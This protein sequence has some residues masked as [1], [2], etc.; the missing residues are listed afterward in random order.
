MSQD[1]QL[2]RACPRGDDKMTPFR[3]VWIKW[4]GSGICVLPFAIYVGS[5][6]TP[7]GNTA[8]DATEISTGISTGTSTGT[9][10]RATTGIAADSAENVDSE[11]NSAG[12]PTVDANIAS[13]E[14]ESAVNVVI[15]PLTNQPLSQEEICSLDMSGAASL[16]GNF[17]GLLLSPADSS[18]GNFPWRAPEKSPWRTDK[19]TSEELRARVDAV[20]PTN[21]FAYPGR[22]YVI[23]ASE[24]LLDNSIR[25]KAA[26]QA[27]IR[28]LAGRNHRST[29]RL[30][31]RFSDILM[32][33]EQG[34]TVRFYSDL[35]KD[36]IVIVTFFYTRCAGICAPTNENLVRL[37]KL[38]AESS[39]PDVRFISISLDSDYDR[40]EV[41]KA[42]AAHYKS[43]DPNSEQALPRWD[44]VC[45]NYDEIN[46]VRKEMGVYDL[47]PVIDSDRSQHAGILSFGNDRTNR[48]SAIASLMPAETIE[49]SILKIA[50]SQYKDP[51][52]AVG[53]IVSTERWE[54]RGPLTGLRPWNHGLSVLGS[55]QKIPD[56]LQIRGT[57]GIRGE[58]L[59]DLVD[60]S[61]HQGLRVL[62]PYP[63][64]TS[65][66][67]SASG[68]YDH[69]GDRVADHLRVDMG[70][71][72]LAGVLSR[73]TDGNLTIAGVTL[74]EN[75]DLRFPMMI[76]D[77]SGKELLIER[78]P[79]CMGKRASARGYFLDGSFYVTHLQLDDLT[80][81]KYAAEE[82]EWQVRLAVSDSSCGLMRIRGRT[83]RLAPSAGAVIQAIDG[84]TGKPAG[85]CT[86]SATAD[87]H[88]EFS[89]Q[90][91][92]LE[93]VPAFLRFKW[94]EESE[95]FMSD[96]VFVQPSSLNELPEDQH[97]FVVGPLQQYSPEQSELTIGSLA[98]RINN[99]AWLRDNVSAPQS[100][101]DSTTQSDDRSLLPAHFNSGVLV[102]APFQLQTNADPA[103][104]DLETS[105]TQTLHADSVQFIPEECSVA[106]KLESI[107]LKQKT[108]TVEGITIRIHSDA[109]F[110]LTLETAEGFSIDSTVN[111]ELQ[112]LLG[113]QITVYGLSHLV[114]HRLP[115]GVVQTQASVIAVR[116]QL[117][118][119]GSSPD[120]KW[121]DGAD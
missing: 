94:N 12:K 78:M 63:G 115:S 22:P 54:I 85:I 112:K 33:N 64:Q 116:I 93:K 71:H 81:Q 59:K 114:P 73:S 105:P 24:W 5:V 100:D 21:R 31:D 49:Q 16:T 36:Q 46:A 9:S 19:L 86:A 98:L 102:R 7:D 10:T 87:G 80:R 2:L 107:D 84:T 4:L 20:D 53:E 3:D 83:T 1:H 106:G 56:D 121:A 30:S 38:L 117:P 92:D 48:W 40:P 96:R 25:D 57:T 15:C 76:S 62:M 90:V 110:P 68:G 111:A 89:L 14:Q 82:P 108:I 97:G 88:C 23:G 66:M 118:G 42:F 50:G 29:G 11:L 52:Y 67:V 39:C 28:D 120:M 58:Q 27:R 77:L 75:P 72:Q 43:E 32:K 26:I 103:V 74:T 104:A 13:D 37:R 79:L 18:S 55:E 69:R 51:L 61:V 8:T 41:L 109:H 99:N 70:P 65:V 113:K 17:P 101:S 95:E 45:G 35:V 119:T 6:L 47:D 34:E 60:S 44:F 91:C